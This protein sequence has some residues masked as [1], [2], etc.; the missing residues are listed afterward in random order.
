MH[1]Y[2]SSFSF[3]FFF[4]SSIQRMEAAAGSACTSTNFIHTTVL[5]PPPA[6]SNY[7]LGG[8]NWFMLQGLRVCFFQLLF[9]I[10]FAF[11]VWCVLVRQ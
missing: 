5:P 3:S 2:R 4:S 11:F 6:S 1:S 9:C 7:T 10:M 8:A